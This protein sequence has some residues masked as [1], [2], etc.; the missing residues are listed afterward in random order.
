MKLLIQAISPFPTMFPT[1][2]NMEITIFVTFNLSSAN[3]F[4]L[5]LFKILSCGN[6]LTL[7]KMVG[8]SPKRYLMLG[9]KEKLFVTCNFSFSHSVFKRFVMQTHKNKGF[10]GKRLTCKS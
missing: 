4:N 9:N 2:S 10:F 8:S 3:A 1:L 5:V 6:G 7:M